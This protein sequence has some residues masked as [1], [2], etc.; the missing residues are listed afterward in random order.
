MPNF[1]KPIAIIACVLSLCIGF[2]AVTRA[3]TQSPNG[4]ARIEPLLPVAA[5]TVRRSDKAILNDSFAGILQPSRQSALGFEAGGRVASMQ[6]DVGD[7]VKAGDE[8]ARLDL[9]TLDAQLAA[10]RAQIKEAEAS[11]AL[12]RVTFDRQNVLVTKGH[13]SPQRLDEARANIDA[14]RARADAAR[15]SLDALAARRQL[16]ILS[17]PYDGVIIDR[18]MD[19]GGIAAPGQSLL[20]LVETGALELR[21]GVPLSEISALR[22]GQ[23]YPVDVEGRRVE[24]VLRSLTGIVDQRTQTV[25]AIFDIA[26]SEGVAP[27]SVARVELENTMEGG[28]FW[29]PL[30][31]LAE[32]TRGLWTVV[33]L[34]ASEGGFVTSKRL[35][36]ILYTDGERAFVRG[37][38]EDGDQIIASGVARVVTGQ[39]VRIAGPDDAAFV[40]ALGR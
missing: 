25:T 32:G 22:T 20:A 13:A 2:A 33:H 11:E 38:L 12:S 14:S 24:A 34:E 18:F 35:I 6:V 37:S 4:Q 1:W 15:A 29:I 28:G 40:Q 23:T 27:G 30:T 3:N 17:A 8:L 16:S 7:R 21:V 36:D 19:E 31:A 5:M 26:G 39:Q 9:R 10:A